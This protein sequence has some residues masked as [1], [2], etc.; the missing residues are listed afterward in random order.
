MTSCKVEMRGAYVC[1]LYIACKT[2]LAFVVS[3]GIIGAVSG[4]CLLHFHL[5][6]KSNH[7][8][9]QLVT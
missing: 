8:G 9:V 5:V 7:T 2:G 4:I 1:A 3:E 6:S